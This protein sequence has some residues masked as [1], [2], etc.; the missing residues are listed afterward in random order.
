MGFSDGRCPVRQLTFVTYSQSENPSS[1]HNADYTRAFSQKR[2]EP[3]P[4]CDYQVRREAR[5]TETISA[6]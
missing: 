2:W 4:F 1:P 6:R 5:S 3:E